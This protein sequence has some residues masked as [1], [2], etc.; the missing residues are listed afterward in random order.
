MTLR[1][2]VHQYALFN[3]LSNRGFDCAVKA[4]S[5][6]THWIDAP[7]DDNLEYPYRD[8]GIDMWNAINRYVKAAVDNIYDD[9]AA[10]HGDTELSSV[11]EDFRDTGDGGATVFWDGVMGDYAADRDPA[12]M[13]LFPSLESLSKADLCLTLT[14]A[15]Y[16]SSF[17]H[18][19]VNYGQYEAFV[20]TPSQPLAVFR[21]SDYIKS[22][23]GCADLKR[24]NDAAVAERYVLPPLP[25]ARS[26]RVVVTIID[27]L[28]AFRYDRLGYQRACARLRARERESLWLLYATPLICALVYSSSVWLTGVLAT[29]RC[30]C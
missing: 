22:L 16:T 26:A 3:E 7:E 2:C 19:V 29:W 6:H 13:Q 28:T 25:P 12:N 9:D 17:Y 5:T 14:T 10:M 21:E 30:S 20:F 1:A 8:D 18:S 4:T 27:A 24:I 15:I 23:K 11:I